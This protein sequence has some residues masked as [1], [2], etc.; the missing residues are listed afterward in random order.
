MFPRLS[1]GV[2]M[3]AL[4]FNGIAWDLGTCRSEKYKGQAD[5]L[6]FAETNDIQEVAAAICLL[7]PIVVECRQWALFKPE[8]SGVWGGLTEQ[9]RK[10]TKFR[11]KRVHCPGCGSTDVNQLEKTSDEHCWSCG[12]SWKI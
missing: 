2:T 8:K 11:K 7:C 1:D 12:L 5:V 9:Q 3:N 4:N 6:W 10:V